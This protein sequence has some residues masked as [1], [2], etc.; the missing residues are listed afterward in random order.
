M[1]FWTR[2]T[3]FLM[4]AFLGVWLAGCSLSSDSQQDD[5]KEPHFVLGKSRVNAMDFSGAVDAFKE[6]L[7]VNPHSAAAHYQLAWLYENKLSDPAAAIYHYQEFL[8]LNPKAGNR[9]VIKQHIYACKE[10]LVTDVMQLPSAP[11]AQQ[12]IEKLAEQNRKMQDELDKWHAYYAA[13][14]AARP[15]ST[16]PAPAQTQPLLPLPGASPQFPTPQA[17]PGTLPG[18][19]AAALAPKMRTHLVGSGETLAAIARKAGVSLAALE[20]VNPN[21]N[22]RRLHSGQTINLPYP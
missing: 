9:D 16:A 18:G 22:P 15:D 14:L 19:A 12:Q 8:Q 3:W 7:E 2:L 10:Q 1:L 4:P 20:A 17:R 21:L 5:E 6:S 13:Q 11:A